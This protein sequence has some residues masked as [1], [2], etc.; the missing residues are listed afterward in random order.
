MKH[1]RE[2]YSNL[3]WKWLR[4]NLIQCSLCFSS[5]FQFI[6]HEFSRKPDMCCR[7]RTHNPIIEFTVEGHVYYSDSKCQPFLVVYWIHNIVRQF[8]LP[9]I[10]LLKLI[11]AQIVH[12]YSWNLFSKERQNQTDSRRASSWRWR[13]NCKSSHINSCQWV[14]NN[15]CTIHSNSCGFVTHLYRY[16]DTDVNM[17]LLSHRSRFM[18]EALMIRLLKCA[19]LI[20]RIITQMIYHLIFNSPLKYPHH[21]ISIDCVYWLE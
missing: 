19:T 17:G 21:A 16:S 7:S 11:V 18:V 1:L 10:F 14:S 6:Q 5:I 20:G 8:V 3:L 2:Q 12:R 4:F 9:K 15:R 13:Y